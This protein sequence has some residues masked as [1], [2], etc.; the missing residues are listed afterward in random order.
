MK[1]LRTRLPSFVNDAIGHYDACP[2]L[3]LD[4]LKFSSDIYLCWI[5]CSCSFTT[6]CNSWSQEDNFHLFASI[7]SSRYVP[8][9]QAFNT[10]ITRHLRPLTQRW[11]C[12]CFLLSWLNLSFL[13]ESPSWHNLKP[14]AWQT[15]S[16]PPTLPDSRCTWP[17]QW[18]NL[19][20]GLSTC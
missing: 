10:L 12:P 14:C 3:W 13:R 9:D 20:V 6:S 17:K 15:N 2:Y 8:Q 7:H 16:L 18:P 19:F 11:L 5:S 4:T 1:R